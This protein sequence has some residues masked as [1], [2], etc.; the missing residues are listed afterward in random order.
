MVGLDDLNG[1]FQPK[2]FW[3]YVHTSSLEPGFE[4]ARSKCH[5]LVA[6]LEAGKPLSHPTHASRHI[7]AWGQLSLSRIRSHESSPEG[8]DVSESSL[9]G[10]FLVLSGLWHHPNVTMKSLLCLWG[11]HLTVLRRRRVAYPNKGIGVLFGNEQTAEPPLCAQA[12]SDL[13][14]IF[15]NSMGGGAASFVVMRILGI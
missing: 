2:W 1:L 6:F 13:E 11:C 9:K 14:Q 5:L 15:S 8:R 12:P 7:S 3:F 10:R 4:P